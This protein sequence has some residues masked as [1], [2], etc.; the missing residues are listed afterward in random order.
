[1]AAEDGPFWPVPHNN[2]NEND[3]AQQWI[4]VFYCPTRREPQGYGIAKFGRSDYAGCAG[5]YHGPPDGNVSFIP[6]APLGAPKAPTRSRTNGGLV[7]GRGGAIIWPREFDK[8]SLVE[9][10]DGLSHTIMFSEKALAL[11]EHGVDGGDNERWNNTGW[12]ED[13]V[14]WHFPPKSEA[15]TYAPDR[16]NGEDDN[17]NRYFGSSHYSVIN[18]GLCD[19]SVPS[20]SF[21]IDALIWMNL[22]VIDDGA[23]NR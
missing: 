23:T 15:A 7:K 13:A 1:M 16:A 12:D 17:W 21:D 8:R 18:A 3:V 14:R 2:S 4:S 10:K 5:F 9:I 22:C 11:T 20:Y 19:G 6:E